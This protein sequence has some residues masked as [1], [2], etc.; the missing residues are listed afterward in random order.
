MPLS[1]SRHAPG[2]QLFFIDYHA[3]G[4]ADSL[5]PALT[6]HHRNERH[7]EGGAPRSTRIAKPIPTSSPARLTEQRSV[8]LSSEPNGSGMRSRYQPVT[9]I[10]V[11]F[12]HQSRHAPLVLDRL[13]NYLNRPTSGPVRIST[14]MT[15][16][17]MSSCTI[18]CHFAL[19]IEH[20]R[21][22]IHTTTPF[23]PLDK[24]IRRSS[25]PTSIPLP[26]FRFYPWRMHTV[27]KFKR[28]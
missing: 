21:L 24:R 5:K 28:A 22:R 8:R 10:H 2:C 11:R 19:S 14:A 15:P 17:R 20:R 7:G 6:L 9:R 12:N 26:Q 3:D 27:F 23:L 16:W 1:A 13:V 4:R 25:A 18:R